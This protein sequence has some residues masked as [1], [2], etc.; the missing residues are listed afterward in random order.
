VADNRSEVGVAYNDSVFALSADV[1]ID[2]STTDAT[3]TITL[4]ADGSNRH[5]GT[6]GAGIIVDAQLDENELL[7]FD[8]NI[9]VEW[10]EFIRVRSGG[11]SRGAIRVFGG[12]AAP[13]NVLLQNLL[14][15]DFYEPAVPASRAVGI[16]LSGIGGKSV[17]IRNTMIWDGDLIGIE[18]DELTDTVIVENCSIDSMRDVGATG[19]DTSLSTFSVRNTII[20]SSAGGVDFTGTFDGASSNNTASDATAPGANPQSALAADLFVT[21]NSDLH[22][23]AGAVAIDTGVDL[24]ASFSNDIDGQ[25]RPIGAQWDRGAD[26]TSS[27][28]TYTI[29]GTVFEDADFTGAASDYDGGANDLALQNVDVELY[30]NSDVYITSATTGVGG[31]YS[32]T[33]LANGTYKIRVRSATIGDADTVPAGGLNATVPGTWPYPLAEMTWGDGSAVYGGQDPTVDDTATGDDAGPGDTYASVTMSGADITGVNF[34]FAYNLIVNT[35]DDANADTVR[36]QQGSLRQFIKNANAIGTAGGTTANSSEFAIP[37][38]GPHTIQPVAA[39]PVID[40]PLILDGYTQAGAQANTVPAPGATD[41]VLL[42]E[43]DGSL[44]GAGVT[45]LDISAGSSTVR[46]LVINGF[47]DR[48]IRLITNGGNTVEGNYVGTDVTGTVDLGNGTRG[49][50]INNSAG[51]TIG[52]ASPAARNVVSGNG[53]YGVY[54]SPAGS[55][56]NFVQGN[57]IGINATDTAA[58]GNGTDGVGIS[59]G[60]SGNTIG[61]TGAVGISGGASGNTIGGT[62]AG[63]RN[64]I[65]GNLNDGIEIQAAGTSNNSVIG[66]YIGTNVA[67]TAARGNGRYGIIL[68]NGANN[69]TI[70]GT[71]PGSANVISANGRHGIHIGGN[72]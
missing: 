27:G 49:I 10:L 8:S 42:I 40:D 50:F 37:G 64:I 28:A 23:K 33:G 7:I 1:D 59:G 12:A 36:S 57:Y 65:S 29:S 47:T 60:A 26:E 55:T 70:G 58:L 30:D 66:N 31:N 24:S 44:A 2:G 56:G 11:S 54:L 72:G 41:A 35:A 52:G 69:T 32:F 46:G 71:L 53:T 13:T 18:G 17:T 14:I 48:G 19:I 61:G 39:L 6:A 34:G 21:P 25:T 9:T 62:G 45:G 4:T 67:G 15:H 20:T 3:H 51:N 5:N 38:A 63:E 68:Y 16:R 43:L 22:L